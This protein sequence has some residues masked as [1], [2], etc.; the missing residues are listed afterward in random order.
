MKMTEYPV[1][2]SFDSSNILI[3]DGSDGT[4]QIGIED[5]A[6]SALH[7][8]SSYNHRLIYRGKNLGGS[9]TTAQKASIQNGTFDD[10]WIG[11]Y[12]NIN[13]VYWRIAD[14]DY[15][16]NTGD[17]S[18]TKHH[19][20]LIPNGILYTDA[21][22]YSKTTTGGYVN[23]DMYK[24]N[25]AAAVSTIK[26]AFGSSVMSHREW[27]CNTVTNGVPS[28]GTWQTVDAVLPNEVMMYGHPHFMPTSTGSS[29]PATG[30]IDKTQLAL[31]NAAP[32]M[33]SVPNAGIWLRD[34]ISSTDFAVVSSTG[35]ATHTTADSKLG[36]RP[37]FAIC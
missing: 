5:A 6:L 9:L 28:D 4:K 1:I 33:I 30:T 17:T 11:D 31:F 22:N 2:N 8:V 23:S 29:V 21:M 20:V 19:A 25:L 7:C 26:T 34:P 35:N 27:L 13:G 10:L 24:T 3:T 32:G 37:V 12:W 14:F 16:Y 15:W 18:C 36:I